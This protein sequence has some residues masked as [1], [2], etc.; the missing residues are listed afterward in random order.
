[1]T[2]HKAPHNRTPLSHAPRSTRRR[3]PAVTRQRVMCPNLTRSRS[4]LS[5]GAA[6]IALAAA[7]SPASAQ[8]NGILAR[9][10]AVITVFSGTKSPQDISEAKR[11][12]ETFIDLD[13][14]S[15]RIVNLEAQGAPEGQLLQPSSKL[16]IKA[17]DVGQT[18]A[19]TLDDSLLPDPAAGTPNIYLGATSVFGL[20]IVGPDTDGDGRSERLRKG[21]PKAQWMPGQFGANG[22]PGTIYKIDRSSGA[23]TPFATL[24]GNNAPGI[25][26][27]VFDTTSLHFYA[28]DL[29]SG[30]IHRI[31]TAGNLI[32]V[33][34]HGEAGRAAVGLAPV[35]DDGKTANIKSA[36]FK[37]GDPA[38]WGFTQPER[39]VW[40]LGLRAGRLYY[41]TAGG[42]TIWSVSIGLDG[43]FGSDT[44]REIDVSGTP[45]NNPITD[46]VFDKA[47]H[48]YVAQRGA[49]TGS[50]DYSVFAKPKQSIVFRYRREWP[51]DPAT[52]GIWSPIPGEIAVGM[53]PDHRNTSGGLAL[54]YGYDQ[55]GAVRRGTC[56]AFV[57]STGDNLRD[58]SALDP[59]VSLTGPVNVHGVQGTART[60][61]RP[62]NEPPASAYFLDFDGRFDEATKQGHAGDIE[63]WQPCDPKA[64]YGSYAPLPDWP[65]VAMPP[66]PLPSWG[67]SPGLGTNLRLQK[68]ALPGACAAGGL[69]ALCDYIVRV[70]NVGDDP[71][72]GPVVIN[73]KLPAAAAGAVMTIAN[74]PPWFCIPISPTEQHCTFGPTV[75][76][77]GD[78]LDLHVN[79]D[80]PVPA[81]V[82]HLD[83]VARIDWPLGFGDANAAD[84]FDVA[85]ASI[86]APHCPPPAGVKTNLKVEKFPLNAVCRDEPGAFECDYLVVVRNT[87]PGLYDGAIKVDE[88]VPAGTT[89]TF[90]ASPKWS[91]TPAAPYSGEHEPVS[92]LPNQTRSFGV[93]LSVPKPLVPGL[94]CEATNKVKIVA[95]AGGSDFNTDPSDD[96]AEATMILPGE[97]AACPA[98]P[99]MSN[100]KLKK[101]GPG[102][103]CPIAG[104]DWACPFKVKVQNF[105]KPYTGKV[106]F[107]DALPFGTPAGT[108]VE[109]QPP[110]GWTC[111]G[112][113]LFPHLYQCSSD[114]P[115]LAHME[116]AEI[117]V[118]VK[119]PV[120]PMAKCEITNT[121][122]IVKAPGGSLINSFAGDDQSSATATFAPA[123]PLDGAPGICLAAA[124]GG[125][126]PPPLAPPGGQETNLSISK[127][128]GPSQVTATGQATSFTITVT[129]TGPGIFN[130]PIE[131]RD[132]LFDGQTVEPSNGSWSAPWTC[133]G[134][135]A[136]GHPEQGL[137]THPAV[138]LDPGESVVLT[139]DIEAPNSFIAPSGSTVNCGYT[140]T[141]EILQPAG[142][143]PQN[144]DAG[145]DTANADVTFA[146]FEKHGQTFCGLGL[147]APP[148]TCPQG[149]SS[150]PVAGKC[151]PPRTNWNGERCT[152]GDPPVKQC[153]ADSIGKYPDCRCKPGTNGSPGRCTPIVII[154]PPVKQCPAD[155]IG[156]H[157]NCRCEPGTKGAPGRCTPI[158]IIDPPVKQ[159]PA[160]SIGKHP[161]CRCKSGTKGKPG[162]CTPIVTI[163]PPVKQCPADSIGKQPNCRCKSGT[164]GTPG[165]CKPVVV[166]PPKQ[167]PKGFRGKPPNC[168]PVRPPVRPE[169]KA[170][171][172]GT[173]GRPPNCKPARTGQVERLAVPGK[174]RAV[175]RQ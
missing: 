20:N 14:A 86:D 1:M 2:M 12:D 40:G 135:S 25:G 95:A 109:F 152:R 104:G 42:P 101:T 31:D 119:V 126:Q 8:E 27:I 121:A 77:P 71:F 26:D 87:G 75:L 160:D 33:F 61:L 149:W 4:G 110:P 92:L 36:S 45:A 167:C 89:A 23:V 69:G 34:D 145:D 38:T 51:D 98:L 171:P 68:K 140:N 116:A 164:K 72:V 143:S 82:C 136:M 133:E 172:K 155:S 93:V 60:L 55:S 100:L 174:Q 120:A 15:A 30:R 62:D 144:T 19:A 46:I 118:T 169:T 97:A 150:T 128:A 103:V 13:G 102:E 107:M 47:D 112:P 53:P 66:S 88:I 129:N 65:P 41:A 132:T 22:G 142:A 17:R 115:N 108:K 83:N 154:D 6:L 70:T 24:P 99:V 165:K 29:D 7:F 10:D 80:L 3:T 137:C 35:A 5:F 161:N 84:D 127:S 173:T 168:K 18:F 125:P 105:G 130:G 159:C 170:C 21:D 50:Y 106:Q 124:M 147:T 49:V 157:P 57:W 151:C 74:A 79:V 134:Q 59:A 39:R 76:L 67:G 85:T 111:D 175:G 122:L 123:L 56:D 90:W 114:N 78:S 146:P 63:I 16:E 9:G 117:D 43:A 162:R 64:E 44:R 37:T 54:G 156:K 96:E 163:D 81:P 139:L 48:M 28:S 148:A 73:D 153:P 52:P 32:D 11:L 138:A 166:D 131:I 58:G 113:A 141:V 91:F 158:V 94:G